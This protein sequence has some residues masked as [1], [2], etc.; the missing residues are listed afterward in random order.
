MCLCVC[1]ESKST[2]TSSSSLCFL[3]EWWRLCVCVSVR[4]RSTCV[5]AVEGD[6]AGCD[7]SFALVL[8][9]TGELEAVVL[10]DSQG[11]ANSAVSLETSD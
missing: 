3:F 1:S 10:W 5:S 6:A 4:Q 11:M 9:R 8:V 2:G 7:G